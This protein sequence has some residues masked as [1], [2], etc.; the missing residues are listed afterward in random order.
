MTI[1]S[2]VLLEARLLDNILGS[3]K[4]YPHDSF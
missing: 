1:K 4:N 3:M 2:C